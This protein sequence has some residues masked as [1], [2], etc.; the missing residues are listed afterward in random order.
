MKAEAERRAQENYERSRALA[1]PLR[2]RILS[3]LDERE[4][5]AT[6]LAEELD[7]DFNK[8]AYHLRELA[9]LGRA[10]LVDED[11]R[12][13]GAQKFYKA[14]VRPLIDMPSAEAMPRALRE[15]VSGVIIKRMVG[16]FELAAEAGTID[17]HP[18]RSLLRETGV[19]DGQGIVEAAHA[20]EAHLERLKEIQAR[21]AGRLND[22]GVGGFRVST[23]TSVIPL[24]EP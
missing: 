13:G 9:R 22:A 14:T 8:V 3:V 17:C 6:E 1:H 18:Q 10:E 21:S 23:H 19:L 2:W 20:C 16:D 11:R 24:S 7:E 4:A 12:R 5:C 15:S